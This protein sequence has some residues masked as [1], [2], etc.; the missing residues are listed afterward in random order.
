MIGDIMIK[1]I[2]KYLDGI[3]VFEINY[4]NPESN[5]YYY[6]IILLKNSIEEI[7]L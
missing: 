1:L 7:N 4:L 3:T 2:A 6:D 5:L